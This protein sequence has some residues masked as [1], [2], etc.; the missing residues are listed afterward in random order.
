MTS[1]ISSQSPANCFFEELKSEHP[2]MGLIYCSDNQDFEALLLRLSNIGTNVAKVVESL[3]KYVQ[4]NMDL[5]SVAIS[6]PRD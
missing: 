2:A 3:E 6:T 4:N 1:A 5:E